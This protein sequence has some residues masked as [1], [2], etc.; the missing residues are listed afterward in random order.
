MFRELRGCSA[1]VC[2]V[3]VLALLS[4]CGNRTEVCDE[5]RAAF[6]GLAA[7]VRTAPATDAAR[8]KQ[9]VG[10]FAARLDSLAKKSDDAKLK[11]TL[12]QAAAAARGAAT[13]AGKGDM[14]P[15][16]RF[17][18]EQPSRVGAACS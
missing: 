6:E 7:Q 17:L 18:A 4:G 12:E 1:M 10:G 16:Q 14:A 15:L 8:W 2:G 13:G 11:K 5:T 3:A 9:A